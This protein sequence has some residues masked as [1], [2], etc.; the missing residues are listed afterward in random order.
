MDFAEDSE[1]PSAGDTLELDDLLDELLTIESFVESECE[2]EVLDCG[3]V[4]R[5]PPQCVGQSTAA[6]STRSLVVSH[7]DV[8]VRVCIINV[9]SRFHLTVG[10]SLGRHWPCTIDISKLIQRVPGFIQQ[11]HKHNSASITLEWRSMYRAITNLVNEKS[12]VTC[13]GAHSEFETII[14]MH[15]LANRLT[16][17]TQVPI[18]VAGLQVNNHVCYFNCG[19]E[20][21]LE[22]LHA[23]VA[24]RF[25]P[26]KHRQGAKSPWVGVL[27]R[28]WP[29]LGLPVGDL[30][31]NIL[32]MFFK[33]GRVTC[34]GIRDCAHIVETCSTA[35]EYCCQFRASILDST[36][37]PRKKKK[38]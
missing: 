37:P 21:D 5:D 27:E 18:G 14:N 16:R 9:V 34:T 10:D 28:V 20:L 7:G 24:K 38:L 15:L 11:P 36:A 4:A 35:L 6:D 30:R 3:R 1:E 29:N 17:A 13:P 12:H 19:F 22:E 2:L 8:T 23:H 26:R 31:R 32:I 25:C 33:A